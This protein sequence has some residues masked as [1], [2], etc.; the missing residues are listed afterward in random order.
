MGS[1]QKM[2]EMVGMSSNPN[3]EQ[4]TNNMQNFEKCMDD[5]LI[6]TKMME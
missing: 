5:M 1:F 6:N 4:M 3:F 2:A